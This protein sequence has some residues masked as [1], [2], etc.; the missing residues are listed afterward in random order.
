MITIVRIPLIAGFTSLNHATG[1][2][3]FLSI[4]PTERVLTP[5]PC[6]GPDGRHNQK[7]RAFSLLDIGHI[8]LGR[9]VVGPDKF[10]PITRS[11]ASDSMFHLG[12]AGL[13]FAVEAHLREG[14]GVGP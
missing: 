8:F 6:R 5:C 2:R 7:G 14:L 12:W 4:R 13:L 3:R 10:M 9:P 11:S 1:R